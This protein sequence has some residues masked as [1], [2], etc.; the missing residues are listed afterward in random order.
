[1]FIPVFRKAGFNNRVMSRKA[2]TPTI[3]D[4]MYCP[5]KENLFF[6]RTVI[7]N[8][9]TNRIPFSLVKKAKE[10]VMKASIM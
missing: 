1:V 5:E 8:S 7:T 4:L 9:G 10:D 2:I 3:P 6:I